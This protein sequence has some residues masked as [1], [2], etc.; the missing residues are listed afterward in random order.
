MCIRDRPK[1]RILCAAFNKAIADEMKE[2]MPP[3]VTALT[4]NSIGFRAL[5]RFFPKWPRV[6]GSKLYKIMRDLN[7]PPGDIFSDILQACKQAKS[8]GY[9]PHPRAKSL[10]DEVELFER[11]ELEFDA[12]HQDL[13]IQ[14]LTRSAEM[15]FEGNIDFDDQILGYTL[16]PSVSWD[17]SLI[18][19]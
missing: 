3:N 13:I 10:I 7:A 9:F 18:H 16:I 1:E 12:K 14:I 11:L 2:V 4:L 19:I 6:D 17:L 15:V 8:M 5:G